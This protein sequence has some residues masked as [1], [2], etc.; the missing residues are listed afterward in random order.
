MK[1]RLDAREAETA[2]N[3]ALTAAQEEIQP[4]ARTTENKVT[5]SWYAKLEAVDAAIRPIYLKYGFSLSY[6]TVAPLVQGN[7]RVECRCARGAHVE[8]FHR[9]AG[10]DT[11]GPK[12]SPTKTVL[13]GGASTET[14]LKRYLACGIFNVVFKDLDDDGTGGTI[15]EAQ[16]S[17][18]R[19]LL[20]NIAEAD[21]KK[22]PLGKWE[23][24]FL[25]L[26]AKSETIEQIPYR[27]YPKCVSTLEGQ[28]PGEPPRANPS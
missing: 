20:T 22:R 4:V 12:G 28:L 19:G 24:D 25:R 1:E 10:P 7:I 13:H 16:A 21:P 11:L 8:R 2:F 6:S 5:G 18:I 23:A 14:F 26:V 27:A 15:D 17:H 9:E 3:E